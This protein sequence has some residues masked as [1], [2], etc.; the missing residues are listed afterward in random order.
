MQFGE[1]FFDGDKKCIYEA[2]TTGFQFFTDVNGYRIYT[3]IDEPS[4]P[5]DLIYT[6]YEL[7]S[8]S[9]D[10]HLANLW[11][12]LIFSIAGG[13]YRY[14]DQ[15]L[16]EKFSL[17]D[18]RFLND[19]AYVPSNYPHNTYLRGNLFPNEATNIDFDVSRIDIQGVSPRIFFS[20]AGE[21]S[22]EDPEAQRIANENLVYAS[23]GGAVWIDV[24]SPYDDAGTET[25]PNGTPE[26][27]VNNTQLA[28]GIAALRGFRVLQV[29]GDLTLD[30]GD[31]VEGYKLIGTSHVNSHLIVNAGA[32]C[33][34][35][36]FE[37]FDIEGVLDGDSE[38]TNCVVGDISYFNGHIHNSALRGTIT[39]AGNLDAIIT[40]CHMLNIL[41]NPIIDCGGSGQNMVLTNWSGR[42]IIKN[43]TVDNQFGIGCDAGDILIDDTCTDGIIAISGTGEVEDNSGPD[44]YVINKITDGTELANLQRIIE[45]LRP[46]HT[47]SGN[48]W[49]WDPIKGSDVHHGDSADRAFK[50]FAKAHTMATNA[51]HDTII[52]V[53]G[54]DS[55]ITTITET[56][57]ITKDY[58]FLRGPGRDVIFEHSV[59]VPISIQTS[60]RG[61]EFSGF[62]IVNTTPNSIAV[63]STG[64]FTL[65]ENLWIENTTNGFSFTT[66]HPLVHSCKIHG[67]SGYAIKME[68]AI[69]HGEI[70]DITAGNAGGT[71]IIINTTTD[72][73]G[74]KMRDT[75]IV[76]SA[77]Y[78]VSLS[79][80][81]SR[82]ISEGSNIV[83]FNTLGE[84]LDLGTD[85]VISSTVQA[86]INP[87]DI[88][89]YDNRTLTDGTVGSS[90]NEWT[91]TL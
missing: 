65:C 88:W 40:N 1:F 32:D 19:W 21:R 30:T 3:P 82:F 39:L 6:T 12:E 4:A 46:H 64:Q 34:E 18:L 45:Y 69:S 90:G 24:L 80:T 61:T 29:I 20:D 47:G 22:V 36:A 33:L 62:R 59:D 27:P 57:N 15:Y 83:K 41:Q 25:E 56:I 77:G 5:Q 86:D 81:T 38:I 67:A 43:T 63:H 10:F 58:L 26:R 51:N 37:A 89:T 16:E 74:I 13:A 84:Y 35:T 66:H 79:D 72:S 42:L 52:I 73:G 60:A 68:G 2:P 9:V 78:G 49:Y 23:F 48:V 87:E 44:C 53:P 7:W 75:I 50:T 17:I 14:T 70:Y 28:V 91:V 55:G 11:C 85:N 31:N 8:R 76:G 71:A 54:D